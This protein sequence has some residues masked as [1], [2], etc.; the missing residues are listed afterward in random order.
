MHKRSLTEMKREFIKTVSPANV[1]V[2]W[3]AGDCYS[4]VKHPIMDAAGAVLSEA[5][6]ERFSW[7]VDEWLSENS[8]MLYCMCYQ[9]DGKLYTNSGRPLEGDEA[10]E[11]LEGLIG[12]LSKEGGNWPIPHIKEL[13]DYY[14][15]L[16]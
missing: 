11:H 14:K 7:W 10:K 12:L 15:T 2:D 6:E 3:D 9:Q 4:Y 13:Q 1:Q 5:D 16:V 8:P